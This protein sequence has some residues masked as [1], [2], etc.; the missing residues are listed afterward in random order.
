MI[1]GADLR[2][3]RVLPRAQHAEQVAALEAP[4][5]GGFCLE[6]QNGGF[7]NWGIPNSW[8]VF[9][10]ENPTKMDDLEAPPF[11]ETPKSTMTFCLTAAERR[12]WMEMREW[13]DY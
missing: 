1:R 12:E 2:I 11:M 13:D 5:M 9:V 4:V 3:F 7:L 10:G 6:L 8:L